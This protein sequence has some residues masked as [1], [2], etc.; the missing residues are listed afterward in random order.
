VS[1]DVAEAVAFGAPE[2][3]AGVVEVTG[4]GVESAEAAAPFDLVSGAAAD[5]AGVVF[6][7]TVFA[8]A[9]AT[10]AVLDAGVSIGGGASCDDVPNCQELGI[11]SEPRMKYK[12]PLA[13]ASATINPK[14]AFRNPC[15]EGGG[16]CRDRGIRTG[17]VATGGTTPGATGAG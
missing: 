12:T 10:G 2:E 3:V 11:G 17:P 4:V 14:K 6:E 5:S 13:S 1:L 9:D 7:G 16:S 8:G 15:P